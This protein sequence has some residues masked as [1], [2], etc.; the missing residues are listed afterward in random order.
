M[1]GIVAISCPSETRHEGVHLTV[2][3]I[4]NLEVS[5]KC[6]GQYEAFYNSVKVS[7]VEYANLFFF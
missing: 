7:P 5:S 1:S 3:G 6:T 2:D 4:V